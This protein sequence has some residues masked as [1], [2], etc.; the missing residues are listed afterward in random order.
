MLAYI[1]VS[2]L[3]ASPAEVEVCSFNKIELVDMSD[4][5]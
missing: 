1:T 3:G 2:H 4:I 5:L